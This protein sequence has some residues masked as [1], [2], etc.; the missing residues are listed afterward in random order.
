ME[1]AAAEAAAD[2]SDARLAAEAEEEA[3][4]KVWEGMQLWK[5]LHHQKND[6]VIHILFALGREVPQILRW[7]MWLVCRIC[8]LQISFPSAAGRDHQDSFP[9]Q[10]RHCS[11]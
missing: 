5:V 2:E 9:G 11:K 6:V 3:L 10:V 1:Q 4:L 8:T 7:S